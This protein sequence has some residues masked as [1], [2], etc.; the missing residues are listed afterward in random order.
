M[1][2]K[3]FSNGPKLSMELFWIRLVVIP[4][5]RQST[6]CVEDDLSIFYIIYGFQNN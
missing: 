3:L 1:S 5:K 4:L 6:K 2:S